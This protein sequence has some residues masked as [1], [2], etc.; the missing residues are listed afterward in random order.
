MSIILHANAIGA[1][2]MRLDGYVLAP[3]VSALVHDP[4]VVRKAWKGGV[5]D[6]EPQ[7]WK[8]TP[9]DPATARLNLNRRQ[10]QETLY[11]AR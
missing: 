1:L 9:R 8:I 4:L 5:K 2:R 11:P 3:A 10:A 7:Y 6:N